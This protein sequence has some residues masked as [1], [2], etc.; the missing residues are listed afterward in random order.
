MSRVSPQEWDRVIDRPQVPA[1]TTEE[2][3]GMYSPLNEDYMF[4]EMNDR[5][6]R[7]QVH[8]SQEEGGKPV[9]R[10]SRRWWR[11]VARRAR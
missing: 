1:G 5:V 2:M 3:R 6:A 4:Q 7:I 8:R 10:P 9:R 11:R